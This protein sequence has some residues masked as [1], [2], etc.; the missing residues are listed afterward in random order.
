MGVERNAGRVDGV[1]RAELNNL[2][3]ESLRRAEMTAEIPE[4][5]RRERAGTFS[6]LY[7]YPVLIIAL[8][9]LRLILISICQ[10]CPVRK[11]PMLIHLENCYRARHLLCTHY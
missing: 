9:N 11:I 3:H 10:R 6:L 1:C 5:F 8:V 4:N 2:L 7:A